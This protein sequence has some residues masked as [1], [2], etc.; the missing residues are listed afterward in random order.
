MEGVVGA[1]RLHDG[2]DGLPESRQSESL[3]PVEVAAAGEVA[4]VKVVSVRA[5]VRARPVA[6]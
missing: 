6:V 4:M 2:H 3:V 1:A 5:V